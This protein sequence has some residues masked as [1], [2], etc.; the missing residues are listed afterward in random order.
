MD[1]MVELLELDADVLSSYLADLTGWLDELGGAEPIAHVLDLGS[2]PGTGTIALARRFPRATITAADASASMVQRLE[3]RVAD[4]EL[5][6]RVH[7][8]RADLDHDWPSGGPFDLAWAAAFLHHLANPDR[9]L[10]RVLESLRPGGLLAVTEM[11]FF[12]RFLPHDAGVGR[13]GLETRLHLVTNTRTPSDPATDLTRAGFVLEAQRRF[14]IDLAAPLGPAVNRYAQVCL[15]KLRGHAAG[16]LD[17]DDQA[18]LDVLVGDGVLGVSGRQ[19]LTVRT[20]RTTWVGRRPLAAHPLD[21]P[22]SHDGVR[23]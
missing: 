10:T 1:P 13:P 6:D 18:A 15:N 23:P 2:G 5:G 22:A 17:A 21:V 16:L 19:D 7:A 3:E 4:L 11:D 9:F 20:G 8:V 14:E 12:P